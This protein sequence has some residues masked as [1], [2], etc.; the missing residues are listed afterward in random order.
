M[1]LIPVAETQAKEESQSNTHP[2][3]VVVVVVL[4]DVCVFWILLFGIP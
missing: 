1:V 4:V 3:H 2:N